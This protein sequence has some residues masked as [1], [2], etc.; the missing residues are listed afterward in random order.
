MSLPRVT[1]MSELLDRDFSY[2]YY[3]LQ[4]VVNVDTNAIKLYTIGWTIVNSNVCGFFF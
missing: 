2:E 3:F 4:Y 1:H